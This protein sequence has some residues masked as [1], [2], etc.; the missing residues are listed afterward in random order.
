M[1]KKT[2]SSTGKYMTINFSTNKEDTWY[3]MAFKAYYNYIP[4]N[5]MCNHWFNISNLLMSPI[6]NSEIDCSWVITA[7]SISSTI[8]IQIE[9]LE[10]IFYSIVLEDQLFELSFDFNITFQLGNDL[11]KVYDGGSDLDD[12]L[13]SMTGNHTLT[14]LSSTGSQLFIS[15]KSD[16]IGP[17]KDFSISLSF[18]KYLIHLVLYDF[19]ID[20][21]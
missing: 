21:F 19:P 17:E 14:H 3:F 16:G 4:I 1:N 13:S 20:S 7:N 10:V 12:E 9:V 8:S 5:S 18:S 2:I 6:S 11:L 15:L